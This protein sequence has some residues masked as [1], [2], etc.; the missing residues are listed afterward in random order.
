MSTC[1]TTLQSAQNLFWIKNKLSDLFLIKRLSILYSL[2]CQGGSET[3]QA[4]N[5]TMFEKQTAKL[6]AV[7]EAD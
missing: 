3:L 7:A 5:G 1:A 2:S 6:N 4:E